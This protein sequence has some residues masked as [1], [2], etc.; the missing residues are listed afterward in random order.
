MSHGSP[1][2]VEIYHQDNWVLFMLDSHRAEPCDTVLGSALRNV[3][4]MMRLNDLNEFVICRKEVLLL[5]NLKFS[6]ETKIVANRGT[7]LIRL[8]HGR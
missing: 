7:S 1:C 6:H 3:V 2:M 4:K 5:Q 8:S